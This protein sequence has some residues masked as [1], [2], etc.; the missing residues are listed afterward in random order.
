MAYWLSRYYQALNFSPQGSH[1][2]QVGFMNIKDHEWLVTTVKEHI[3]YNIIF[4]SL[5]RTR[6]YDEDKS[7]T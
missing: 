3:G 4:L 2:F 7:V 5:E 6:R 1:G